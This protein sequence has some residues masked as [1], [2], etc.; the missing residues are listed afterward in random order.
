MSTADRIAAGP[1]RLV[2]DPDPVDR[3]VYDRALHP[4][5]VAAYAPGEYVGQESLMRASEILAVA[6]AAGIGPG[7]SVLDLCCGLAGPGRLITR[8]LCCRYLG[9]DASAG[10]VAAARERAG[11]LPCRFEVRRVPPVPRGRFDV[12]LL[13]ETMLAFPDKRALVR[14]VSAALRPGGRFVFTLE[15]G[16]PLTGA[17][18]RRMPAAHT[19]WPARLDRMLDWL[20]DAGLTVRWVEDLTEPHR[21]MAE[22]L[23]GAFAVES[24]SIAARLGSPA[25]RDLLAA[26][27]LWSAWL[28]TGRVR[29]FALVAEQTP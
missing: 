16:A 7:V 8:A 27:R 1:G 21:E 10:A 13:F 25:V 2:V 5:R 15:E 24:A 17:E 4:A 26:H 29:K 20:A 12:V 6:R 3:A 23:A 28:G 22:A 18:R 19:V 11:R 14:E 9:V